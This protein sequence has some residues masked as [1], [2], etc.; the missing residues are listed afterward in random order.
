MGVQLLNIM[1]ELEKIISNDLYSGL[2]TTLLYERIPFAVR[3][4][5]I[6]WDSGFR[7]SGLQIE[8]LII[9]VDGVTLVLPDDKMERQRYIPKLIGNYSEYTGF[10]DH[11]ELKDGS[12]I[13]LTVLRKNKPGKGYKKLEIKGTLKAQRAYYDKDERRAI[14]PGGPHSTQSGGPDGSWTGWYTKRIWDWERYLDGRWSQT[15]QNQM[16]LK[17][18]LEYEPDVDMWCKQYPGEFSKRLKEDF[19]QV[20]SCLEG[21]P[22]T[23]ASDALAFREENVRRQENIA[24][25]GDAAWDAFIKNHEILDKLPGMDLVRDDRSPLTGKL[26]VLKD[27]SW[28]R[29]LPD[30]D[31]SILA[32]E[33]S[34]HDC[35]ISSAQSNFQKFFE[36]QS[37]YRL[38]VSPRFNETMDVIG[39][40][41]PQ[42]RMV[43][44]RGA[45]I[46]LDIEPVA[47]RQQ[48]TFFADL[49]G[50]TDLFAGEELL[51]SAEIATLRDDASPTDVVRC[52]IAALKGGNDRMWR[53][54]YATWTAIGG[55]G[56]P[57]YRPFNP[58]NNWE[59]DWNYAR[60]VILN[61][62]IYVEPIWES[63]VR[64]VMTGKE[65]EG[66]PTI[67]EVIVEVNHIGHF[68]DVPFSDGKK[69]RVFSIVETHRI[70]QL[71][72]LNNGPWKIVSRQGI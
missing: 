54:L 59:S 52:A 8:D 38:K 9:A 19:E 26:I 70:W 69:D 49:T 22:A 57:Y 25:A 24:A 1:G 46:G 43:V 56:L 27:L 4:S 20:R 37:R 65:F 64:T 67:D 12:S 14:A 60:N 15:L 5:W 42:T 39:R 62:V 44:T 41:L 13:T 50:T 7:D 34:G 48:K 47:I 17:R 2:K 40:I 6:N 35:F 31:K 71:Q 23:L 32:G 72:R 3:V 63:D 66:A 21:E 51:K 55:E 11:P 30:G 53:S 33:H 45:T 61:K 16:E 58:Y 18:H 28:R 68:E 10:A 29:A 36:Y